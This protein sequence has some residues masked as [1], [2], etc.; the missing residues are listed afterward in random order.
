M[1]NSFRPCC[2]FKH[3]SNEAVSL[4]QYDKAFSQLRR[5]MLDGKRDPRCRK[6][7]EEEDAGKHSMRTHANE[8]HGLEFKREHLTEKFL[9]P[10]FIE[11][12]LDNVCNLEC[13]MCSSSFSSK[14]LKR[15]IWLNENHK[16]LEDFHADR[17]P[18]SRYE[19][20]KNLEVDWSELRMIKLLGG[21]PFLSPNFLDFLYFL[22]MRT[23]ISK[24]S[25][26]LV[27]NCT[28]KMSEE[29]S[30]ILNE[31]KFI[32]FYGSF[33]GLPKMS[34]YQRQTSDW[35]QCFDNFLEY[36]EL[37]KNRQMTIHQTFSVINVSHVDESIAFYEKHCDTNSW[38][39]D[40]YNFSFMSAPD[41][42]GDWVLSRNQNKKL[43]GVL[44]NRKYDHITWHKV[45]HTIKTLD[46]YYGTSLKEANPELAYQLEINTKRYVDAHQR[47]STRDCYYCDLIDEM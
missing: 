30:E 5:D 26:E 14:L 47:P 37:L 29:I 20:L 2:R 34:M 19:T 46:Q 21:E 1:N 27:S 8:F 44:K 41:W 43:E 16:Y 23:D 33:D 24:I 36:G 25:M 18:K 15:D 17:I 31:F 3:S 6:C 13:R 45:L 4:D 10:V 35:Y 7:W 40:E 11:I 22:D 39:Y 12:S 38:S 32:Y 28:M 9:K 42:F